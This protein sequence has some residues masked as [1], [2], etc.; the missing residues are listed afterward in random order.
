M[1]KYSSQ[2]ESYVRASIRLRSVL[3]KEGQVATRIVLMSLVNAVTVMREQL[4]DMSQYP[5]LDV[6]RDLFEQLIAK[7]EETLINIELYCQLG[8][9]HGNTKEDHLEEVAEMIQRLH[10][11]STTTV[12]LGNA[13]LDRLDKEDG[14]DS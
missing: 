6:P 4:E 8:L 5:V 1:N 11:A 14:E 10:D 3:E 9:D 13:H 7:Y 2:T 12:A